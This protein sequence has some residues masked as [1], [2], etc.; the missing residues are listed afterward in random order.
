MGSSSGGGGKRKEEGQSV[1]ASVAA[2]VRGLLNPLYKAKLLD[3]EQFK[4]VVQK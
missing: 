3:K 1:E 4:A 2:F